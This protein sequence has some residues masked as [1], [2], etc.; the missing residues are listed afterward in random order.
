MIRV[1]DADD[2][3]EGEKAF[4]HGVVVTTSSKQAILVRVCAIEIIIT[5]HTAIAWIVILRTSTGLD[6]DNT[7]KKREATMTDDEEW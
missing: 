5:F 3:D 1:Q 6:E 2:D 4:V 7:M